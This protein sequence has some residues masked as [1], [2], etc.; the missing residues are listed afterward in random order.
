MQ[1]YAITNSADLAASLKDRIEALRR[2][3]FSWANG[4]IEYLQIREKDLTAGEL[5]SLSS[6]LVREVKGS[7]MKVLVNGRADIAMAAG[8]HGVHLPGGQPLSPAEVRQLFASRGQAECL[9]SVAAHS[10]SEARVAKQSGADLLLF[11]PVFE[12]RIPGGRIPGQGLEEL[13]EVCRSVSPTP[14]FALGG[15]NKENAGQCIAA[16]AQGIAAIR[17]FLTEEW[18]HLSSV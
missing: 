6:A 5:E 14:V 15:V 9:I 16:G 17:L 18:R 10:I 7:R 1:L 12:K 13:S 4:G 2:L 8:A 11:A 3:A